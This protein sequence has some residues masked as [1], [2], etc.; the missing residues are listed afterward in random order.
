M[1][2]PP[3]PMGVDIAAIVSSISMLTIP[4]P[5]YASCFYILH[6]GYILY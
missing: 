6:N 5:S 4:L 3:T 2:I 1:P